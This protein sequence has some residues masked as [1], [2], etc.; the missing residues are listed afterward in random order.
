LSS[1][2]IATAS[3]T[4]GDGRNLRILQQALGGADGRRVCDADHPHARLVHILHGFCVG[5]GRDHVGAFAQRIVWAERNPPLAL[6]VD[7]H[8]RHIDIASFERVRRKSRIWKQHRLERQIEFLRQRPGDIGRDSL[9]FSGRVL[10]VEKD[11][12][13]RC[14]HQ[15]DAQLSGGCKFFHDRGTISGPCGISPD[16]Y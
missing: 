10:D 7:W 5:R 16:G 3:S 1:R 4:E 14:E 8:E 13:R 15:R 12:L 6:L 9:R 11:R 2:S